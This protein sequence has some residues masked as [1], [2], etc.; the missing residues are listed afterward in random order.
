[1]TGDSYLNPVNAVGLSD[2]KKKFCELLH[3]QYQYLS[4]VDYWQYLLHETKFHRTYEYMRFNKLIA[5]LIYHN[6]SDVFYVLCPQDIFAMDDGIIE[7]ET[8]PFPIMPLLAHF[9][10]Q[11]NDLY[12]LDTSALF[13]NKEKT[14]RTYVIFDEPEISIHNTIESYL[15]SK[16]NKNEANTREI[17]KADSNKF[18]YMAEIVENMVHFVVSGVELKMSFSDVHEI[19]YIVLYHGDTSDVKDIEETYQNMVYNV[20]VLK[21]SNFYYREWFDFIRET[22]E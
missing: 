13:Y 4:L 22:T 18:E 1:M 6:G 8:N 9:D 14:N 2:I 15:M 12:I 16:I 7:I 10:L 21:N 11:T 17:R 20:P 5:D 19:K 3:T